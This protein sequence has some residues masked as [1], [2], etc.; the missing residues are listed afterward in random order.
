M[1]AAATVLA[2]TLVVFFAGRGTAKI[3]AVPRRPVGSDPM[4]GGAVPV[5]T[6][7]RRC[8]EVVIA[9]VRGCYHARPTG[10]R[11]GER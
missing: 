7:V 10:G 4:S 8:D 3:L 6:F 2:V 5:M 9:D 1:T 11:R